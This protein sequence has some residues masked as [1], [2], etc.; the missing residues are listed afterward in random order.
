MCRYT[1]LS[2][3]PSEPVGS[4]MLRCIPATRFW[5]KCIENRTEPA[6]ETLTKIQ[7][8]GTRRN[9]K[10]TGYGFERARMIWVQQAMLSFKEE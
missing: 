5:S 3:L 6:A 7:L 2:F 1:I 10:G 4:L 9:I 8:Q